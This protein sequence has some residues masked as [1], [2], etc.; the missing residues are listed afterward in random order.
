MARVVIAVVTFRRPEMLRRLLASL[1]AAI[2]RAEVDVAEI[3]VVDNDPLG[4]AERV[5]RDAQ[6]A[7]ITYIK[8]EVPG[9]AAARNA[10][11][12]WALGRADFLVFV[13]D[14]EEVEPVWLATL[15]DFQKRTGADMVTGPVLPRFPVG[16]RRDIVASGVFAP[17]RFSS[18]TR[19]EEAATN[20]LCLRVELFE[21]RDPPEWF[22]VALGLSGGSDAELTRRLVREGASLLWCDEAVAWEEVTID[23]ARWPW[24]RARAMRVGYI[25]CRL[26]NRTRGAAIV[27]GALRAGVAS[28]TLI[29]W[30]LLDPPRRAASMKRLGRGLG[31]IRWAFSLSVMEYARR[32]NR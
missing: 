4:S 23:R 10:A 29:A 8:E 28:F 27:A 25:D 19:L 2:E 5:A 26:R 13:D 6:H 21:Q 14:D 30:P 12:G 31:Y 11:I 15:V 7:R 1:A 22:D 24:V 17:L 32:R 9:I 16:T 20:N 18:G 3:L